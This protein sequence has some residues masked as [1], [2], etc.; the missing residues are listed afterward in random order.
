MV[1]VAPR[2]WYGV[3]TTGD[4]LSYRD[5]KA[6]PLTRGRLAWWWEDRDRPST[7]PILPRGTRSA[8]YLA[9]AQ[10]A[11]RVEPSRLISPCARRRQ[12]LS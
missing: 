2:P 11:F 12:M 6:P 5:S 8:S 7:A 10:V 1:A 9:M 4:G 3:H